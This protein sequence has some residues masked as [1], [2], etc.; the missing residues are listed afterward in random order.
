[1]EKVFDI[2]GCLEVIDAVIEDARV[3]QS[4]MVEAAAV[5]GSVV[6]VGG[7]TSGAPQRKV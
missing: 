4:K 5:P 1:M 3:E 7:V 2:Q 6:E